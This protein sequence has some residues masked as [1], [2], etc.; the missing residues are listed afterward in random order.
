MFLVLINRN[1]NVRKCSYPCKVIY[2]YYK[3]T[4]GAG[5]IIH[6]IIFE[7]NNGQTSTAAFWNID[8]EEQDSKNLEEITME[9]YKE[10]HI[11]LKLGWRMENDIFPYVHGDERGIFRMDDFETE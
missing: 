11:K 6:L 9:E 3:K 5:E 1:I 7:I 8:N 4:N 10:H 2:K